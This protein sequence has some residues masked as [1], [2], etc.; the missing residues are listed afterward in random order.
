MQA[1]A[2]CW[3]ALWMTEWGIWLFTPAQKVAAPMGPLGLLPVA[4]LGDLFSGP[5]APSIPPVTRSFHQ[6]LPS[7][8]LWPTP[9][10][11]ALG[12]GEDRLWP[13]SAAKG[14]L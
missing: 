6:L 10:V 4:V 7:K 14:P 8:S 13:G 12:P 2:P 9:G 11:M 1:A 3:G 5:L